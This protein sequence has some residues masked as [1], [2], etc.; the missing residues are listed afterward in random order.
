MENNRTPPADEL[1]AELAR[2]SLPPTS[3]D[4]NLKLVGTNSPCLHCRPARSDAWRFRSRHE[5]DG[6]AN[7][8]I[9]LFCCHQGKIGLTVENGECI[10]DNKLYCMIRTAGASRRLEMAKERQRPFGVVVIFAVM[11]MDLLAGCLGVLML[12]AVR[13]ARAEEQTATAA[14]PPPADKSA[15]P[16]PAGPTQAA[17]DASGSATNQPTDLGNVIVTADLDAAREQIAPS[18][19]AVTY[20]IG[21]NQIQS[22]SQGENSS[23][24][25]VLLHAPGVVQEEFG[26][27]HV[28]G[29]HGDVQYRINGVS[30]PESLNGFGQEIDPH[31]VNSVTLITGTMP[32]QFGNRTAGII[33]VTTKTGAQLD[34]SEVSLYGG[35]Y[36]TIHPSGSFGGT[37]S[38]LDYFVTASYLHDDLGIDNTTS[39]SDP[40]HD[41]TEQEKLFGYFSHNFDKTSRVTLLLSGSYSDFEIPD[42]AGLAPAYQLLNGPP[43]DSSIVNEKQNEQNYYGV[44]SYQKSAGNLSSQ[45]SVFTRYTDLRFSPDS[46]QDVLFNGNAAQVKNSDFANGMQADA[47]Y[48]LGDHHT[49]RA[50]LLA[51][52][53]TEKLDNT[54][55]VFP[56]ASQFSPSLSGDNLPGPTLQSSTAPETITANSGNS[57][58]TSGIYLQDEWQLNDRLTL[59]YGLR[60]DRFDVSFDHEDQISPRI[61]LV[62]QVDDATTA[63]IGYARYFMP[64]TLQ[65]IPPSTVQAFEYTTDAPFNGRDD[66]PKVERDHYFD[67][68]LSWQI[69]SSWQ[70]T[71]DSF[72]K[73]AKHLLDDGQFGTAVILNNF[74]YDSGQVYGAELSST[75][76][77]G[78]F[79]VYGNFSYVQTWAKEIDS[80]QN[81]F[82]N[83]ELAYLSANNIQLDHQGRLTGSAGVSYAFLKNTRVYADLLYGNG[84]RAGFANLEKLPSY[85]I[86]SVGV[87]HVWHFHSAGISALKLRVDCLNLFD[88]VY[89]IRNGTGLGIAAPAY[90]PRRA[91]YAGIT[92]VF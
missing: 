23:F 71:A 87:E 38:N 15:T 44:L 49:L 33:D 77:K 12:A 85:V 70:V 67:A 13:T 26:E 54:S 18:L 55:T 90:G 88:Q 64:P 80:V 27:I 41:F 29:D 63:H 7:A 3:H 6:L 60:Y 65:Y 31:L 57:G 51:T 68:G 42:T 89:E 34:G 50:G 37:T 82:P 62:W 78:P 5:G 66:A 32:A 72:C 11:K 25:Q 20:K 24:Q 75:L 48:T 19:G 46:V 84:L 35:S 8:R 58:L 53:D 69:T 81:E 9:A 45:V 47:S 2:L 43:A 86:D 52:Y 22:M 76:K 14:S 74:N 17:T 79:S 1:K 39:S 56:S 4:V 92:A 73:L 36:D 59:N 10:V 21:A 91:F 16:S 30:L 40:L 28:R 61:N 83:N